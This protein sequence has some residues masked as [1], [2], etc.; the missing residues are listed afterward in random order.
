MKQLCIGF[1]SLLALAVSGPVYAETAKPNIN[2]QERT[3]EATGESAVVT[4]GWVAHAMFAYLTAFQ[5]SLK[6]YPPIPPGAPDSY[7]P[8]A[9]Q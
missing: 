2:P 7:A 4:H 6:K 5:A 3:E 1:L 9:G 8:A